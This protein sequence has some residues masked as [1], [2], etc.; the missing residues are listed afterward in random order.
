MA[1]KRLFIFPC[2]GNGIEALDCVDGDEYEFAGFVD[3]DSMK[4]AAEKRWP[5]FPRSVLADHPDAYVLAVPGGPR[6]YTTRAAAI[7]SLGLPVERLATVVHRQATVGRSVSLGRNCL[8]MAGAVITSNA[9]VGDHVCILPNS[10]VHHDTVI[11]DYTLIGCGVGIAGGV[12]VGRNCYIGSGSN[13][14][15]GIEVGD[16][17]LIGLGSNVIRSVPAG[18]VVAGNPARP[19]HKRAE[20]D[21]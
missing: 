17:T 3:D 6:T 11:G 13:L 5:I 12:T 14:I 1:S 7:A 16:Q 2:N 4:L 15:H 19:L 9:R 10:V 8:V 21:G 18:S 20:V